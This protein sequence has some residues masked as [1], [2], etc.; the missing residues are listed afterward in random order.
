MPQN[1]SITCHSR[2]RP[3][4]ALDVPVTSAVPYAP[5]RPA[6]GEVNVCVFA[7]VFSSLFLFYDDVDGNVIIKSKG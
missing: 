1:P 4:S 2:P 3:L 6:I 7:V 5:L